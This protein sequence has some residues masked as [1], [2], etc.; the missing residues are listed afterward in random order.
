MDIVVAVDGSELAEQTL[1]GAAEQA[2]FRQATLH[3]I[4]VVYVP[5]S[6]M[7]GMPFMPSNLVESNYEL[8]ETVRISVWE[9]VRAHL[10]G[11]EVK[12]IQVDRSGYPPDEIVDYANS[13]K[14]DL[15]VL[16][17]RGLGSLERLFLG[18]TSHRVSHLARCDVLIVK[19]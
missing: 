16:G 13:V 10:E 11:S 2:R 15:I 5:A 19:G 8:A 14:A 1:Q 9:R 7:A 18:S 3:V 12:W 4:H 17:N 6:A